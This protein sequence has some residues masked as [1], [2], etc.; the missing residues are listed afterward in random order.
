MKMLSLY[1]V[2]VP[3]HQ[4]TGAHDFEFTIIKLTTWHS[5]AR[6]SMPFSDF[7]YFNM[8]VLQI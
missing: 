7:L 6:K 8:N 4:S 3:G 2:T 1:E 5:F